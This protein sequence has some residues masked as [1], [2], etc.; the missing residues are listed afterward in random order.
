MATRRWTVCYLEDSLDDFFTVKRIVRGWSAGRSDVELVHFRNISQAIEYFSSPASPEPDLTLVDLSLGSESGLDFIRRLQ[1]MKME[2][3]PMVVLSS[4][5]RRQ[6]IS[7]AYRCGAA[8]Y[9]HKY[10]DTKQLEARIHAC[11][12]YWFGTVELPTLSSP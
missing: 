10:V 2:R 9:L 12:D 11:L 4:S 1:A 8:G 5:R 7:E 6:H 3:C